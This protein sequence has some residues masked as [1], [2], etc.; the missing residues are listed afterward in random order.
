M[1]SKNSKSITRDEHEYLGWVKQQACIVCDEPGPSDAHHI[2]QGNHFTTLPLC[3]SCHQG[4]LL[5]WH[6]QKRAWI[7]RKMTELTALNKLIR[8]LCSYANLSM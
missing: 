6:G 2:E 5:G 7:T 3:E 4:P 8:I 1:R